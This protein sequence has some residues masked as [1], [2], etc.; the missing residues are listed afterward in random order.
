[1]QHGDRQL[2]I[3]EI[4]KIVEEIYGRSVGSDG[5]NALRGRLDALLDAFLLESQ[6]IA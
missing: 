3:S 6:A 4:G 1:M 2:L 5:E